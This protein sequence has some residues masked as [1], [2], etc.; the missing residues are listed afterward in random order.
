MTKVYC[1]VWQY[2]LHHLK[3]W[4]CEENAVFSHIS[5]YCNFVKI[6]LRCARSIAGKVPWIYH[7]PALFFSHSV[8]N[9]LDA[10]LVKALASG[11][12]SGIPHFRILSPA[13]QGL[14]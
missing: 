3:C 8:S 11:S 5:L 2:F 1:V 13:M 14:G 9:F 7:C 4:N 12:G 6:L 10:S